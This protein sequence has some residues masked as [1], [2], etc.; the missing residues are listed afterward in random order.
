MKKQA[1]KKSGWGLRK[2]DVWS[3]E[4]EKYIAVEGLVKLYPLLLL[5]VG[6]FVSRLSPI[7]RPPQVSELATAVAPVARALYPGLHCLMGDPLAVFGQT[8]AAHEVDEAGGEVQLAA[9][10]TG[11]VVEGEG[12][13]VVVE[14]FTWTPE[15]RV[16][17]VFCYLPEVLDYKQ[18]LR[19]LQKL[20]LSP[21]FVHNPLLT[22]Y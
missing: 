20:V 1:K 17:W 13:V 11:G 16:K 6:S 22:R 15:G 21:V 12:V 18:I 9:K 8:Q 4:D 2:A 14:S 3:S 7:L 19:A 5:L 10:L